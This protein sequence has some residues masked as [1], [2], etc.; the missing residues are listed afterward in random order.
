[1]EKKEYGSHAYMNDFL[2]V[3]IKPYANTKGSFIYCAGANTTRFYPITRDRHGIASN[4]VFR[5]VQQLKQDVQ[6]VAI[7]KGAATTSVQSSHCAGIVPKSD[8]DAWYTEAFVVENAADSFPSETLEFAVM[9][10]IKRVMFLCLPDYPVPSQLPDAQE[11]Q[12]MF[13]SIIQR[14]QIKYSTT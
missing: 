3:I 6:A 14:E 12:K 5:G 2:F 7:S 13:D 4:P 8:A 11:L 1:M 9:G 10:L